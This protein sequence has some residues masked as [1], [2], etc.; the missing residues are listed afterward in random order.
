MTLKKAYKILFPIMALTMFF[1]TATCFAM[2]EVTVDIP[3]KYTIKNG[4]GRSISTSF[5]LEAKDENTPMPADA[6]GLTKTIVMKKP[7]KACFGKISYTVPDVYKYTI[8]RKVNKIKDLKEDASKFEV[9]VCVLS[10]ET[11]HLIVKKTGEKGK[12]ELIYNDIYEPKKS[13]NTGD[14]QN[15]YLYLGIFLIA[16][17]SLFCIAK[18]RHNRWEN[19]SERLN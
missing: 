9:E 8:T 7:G 18:K 10:D 11:A 19:E 6:T 16:F 12:S 13:A 2:N 14:F 17:V 15:I 5:T 3:L 4:T 1:S